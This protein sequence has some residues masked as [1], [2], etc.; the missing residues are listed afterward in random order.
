M[1]NEKGAAIALVLLIL[2]VVSLILA[3]V[4]VQR[5]FDTRL[6]MAQSNRSKM[7]NLADGAASMAFTQVGLKESIEYSGGQT[8]DQVGTGKESA[9]GSW[10]A[11]T[12]FKGYDTDPQLLAGYELGT[13]EGYHVQ[14]W[15]AEG[16]SGRDAAGELPEAAVSIAATKYARN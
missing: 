13:A 9:V 4:V 6:N 11:K 2:G 14:F 8:T 16:T 12:V 7:F 1:K 3:G 15:V 10:D 5:Q